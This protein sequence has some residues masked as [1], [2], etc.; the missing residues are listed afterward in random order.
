M[1]R[2][3]T[4]ILG[5]A[6]AISVSAQTP[7]FKPEVFGLLNLEYPG[8]EKVKSL[9]AEG[10][11]A[12]AAEA[13][14]QYFKE[15]KGIRTAEIKD[16]N[17]VKV[18]KEQQAWADDALEH[19]F[20]VHKG[21]QPSFNYGQDI[22]WKYWPVKDNELRWQLHRHKWFVPMGRAY[23]VSKDEKYAIEWTKQYIDWIRKNPYVNIKKGEYEITSDSQLKADAENARFAWRP[24][25]VSHRLQD[26]PIQF[27]LFIDSPSF[28]AEFLTE[29]LVNYHKQN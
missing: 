29:F 3:F 8:M 19:T 16:I 28:T 4:I 21:Y 5:I 22:N 13:L 1:K 12:D 25:E 6:F 27:Q 14:L 18:T 20:F 7:E 11:D 9:H 2:I 15:R 26:Q 23:R 24:L 10:K 17:K